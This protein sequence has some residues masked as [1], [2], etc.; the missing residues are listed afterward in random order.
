MIV[1][2]AI[3]VSPLQNQARAVEAAGE[4]D[5]KAAYVYNFLFFV[6]WHDDALTP[7]SAPVSIA[8]LGQ[9]P[10][11]TRFDSV[12][13]RHV[14]KAQRPLLISHLG[15]YKPG[16]NLQ[17]HRIIFIAESEKKN[18]P[19]ILA[20]IQGA[21]VLTVGDFPSFLESGG[22]LQFVVDENRVRWSINRQAFADAGLSPSAQL[23]RNAHHV[24][25]P[26]KE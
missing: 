4:Y 9:D 5:I 18:L 7:S 23:L 10:F 26:S 16:L 15:H 12:S 2:L 6:D 25:T 8:I 11:E 20:E 19:K 22:M 1:F 14:G 13:G 3:M 17:S 21:K 24:Y